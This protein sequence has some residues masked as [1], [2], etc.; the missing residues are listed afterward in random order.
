VGSSK[1]TG[2]WKAMPESLEIELRASGWS[3]VLPS[4]ANPFHWPQT[5]VASPVFL[6]D[7]EYT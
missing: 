5:P 3:Q 6:K 2:L 4:S 7:L 1:V